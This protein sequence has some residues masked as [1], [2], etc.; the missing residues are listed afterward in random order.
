MPLRDDL[1]NPIEGDNPSGANLRYAPVF[2]KIKEARRQ[3]DDAPQGEWQRERKSADF[4]QVAK[5]AGDTLATKSK[6]VQLAAWLTEAMLLQEGFSGLRQGL[7]LLR[8]L[9]ANFW[10]TLYPEVEDGDLEL[11][12]APLEWV[13]TRLE[14]LV[15]KTPITRGG[16][17]FYKYKESRAVGTEEAAA[18]S[19][20]KREARETAVAEGKV[21]VEDFD[22]DVAS[23]PTT[24][25]EA[26][27]AALDG[28]LGSIESLSVLCEEKF[29]DY[30]P[31]F[32]PLRTAIEEVRHTTNQIL[33]KRL[34]QE[35]R[36]PAPDEAEVEQEPEAAADSA[37]DLGAAAAPARRKKA[38]VG[39]D[40]EDLDDV[41]ARL[42]AVARFLR[43]Q[44]ASNPGSYLLLRGYRWGELRGF[45]DSPDPTV[46]V[47]PSS[48]VRQT[49][50]RLSLEA[51]WAAL[52][53]TAETAMAQ[54]CGRAWLDLQR[55]V[56]QAAVESGYGQ[57]A[58]AI[59][60]ELRGLLSDISGVA[61]WT[62]MDDTPTANVETQA[63]LKEIV[64][65]AV[66]A[67]PSSHMFEDS[68][69][70]PAAPGEAPPPDTYT[71]ALDAARSG[72]AADAIQML[73]D[74]TQRQPSGRARFQRKL[75]LAQICMI[76]GH[77]T[78]A[79]PILEE[80]AASIAEHNLE[81]WEAADAV[82]HPLAMLY[83]CLD[84][85]DG[86]AQVR[87]KLYAQI[88]R[89]DPVQALQC[90]G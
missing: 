90:T 5:L 34:D 21:T 70:E 75:Q 17:N 54:P 2:D 47:P 55:Y 22:K 28:C 31:S 78:L 18:Q 88:S 33:Q 14:D 64:A 8:G 80:L 32:M 19:E 38:A 51:N 77:E 76:T 1:L 79:R 27:V 71:L 16:L 36:R 57:V 23:T 37:G 45:G 56:V 86:D 85:L 13:G 6:D 43:Q 87:Q 59:R 72:R 11:R 15:R 41:T 74:E 58:N 7:D 89:L 63:W 83:R 25:Y 69:Q 67:G 20:Q 26:W 39:L 40:P 9:I 3:D 35:G 81:D 73:A 53:E 29:S 60:S 52:L 46:L 49:I 66:A 84:K 10:D 30:T 4:K 50:K 24:Q 44:D 62:L 12:A 65:P 82:A 42:A 48:E 68:P 61:Q